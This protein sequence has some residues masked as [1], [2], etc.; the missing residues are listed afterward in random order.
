MENDSDE[1][2]IDFTH[3]P[4]APLEIL[5]LR[6]ILEEYA[7]ATWLRKK[8]RIF[9]PWIL[10]VSAGLYGGWQWLVSYIQHTPKG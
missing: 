8:I 9:L 4:L 5:K 10:G 7:H 1:P 2:V 3:E 6:R